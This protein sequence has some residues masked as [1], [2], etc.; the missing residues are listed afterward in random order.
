ME[1]HIKFINALS[2]RESK[3][4]IRNHPSIHTTLIIS[5]MNATARN[6]I[7]A[8]DVDRRIISLKLLRNQIPQIRKFTGTQ[9]SLKLVRTDQRK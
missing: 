3:K 1:V 5:G 9:K 7:R 8:S 6:Q 4:A 2:N